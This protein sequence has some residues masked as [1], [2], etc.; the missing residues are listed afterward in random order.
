MKKTLCFIGIFTLMFADI[1]YAQTAAEIVDASRN[2]ISANTVSTRSRMI[3]TAKDGSKTERVIDQYSKDDPKGNSRTIIVFQ[4]PASVAG[5]RF[6][7]V[8]NP[9]KSNNQWIFLPEFGKSRRVDA[10]EGSGNFMGTDMSY[11]DISSANRDPGLDTHTL[12]RE[13]N[14]NGQACYVIQSIPKDSS[15]QYSKIIQ[16]IDKNTKI[17]YKIELYDKRGT[18]VK[19]LETSQVREVQGR[20]TPI[21]TKMTTL[22]AGTSTTITVEIIKYDDP[23][24]EGVFTTRYL[25][26]GR[27]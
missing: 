26:T 10:S 9:G 24:P 16:W 27:P 11:D 19:I 18:Q 17:A 8:E 14:M 2:R 4:S 22:A 15:Y 13:E 3:I 1:I 7:T 23:I 21:V 12:I 5:T 20:L 25:E 6:L